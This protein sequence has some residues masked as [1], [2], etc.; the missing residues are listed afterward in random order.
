M[1]QRLDAVVVGAG[2]GGLAAAR[3]LLAAGLRVAVFEAASHPGGT[4]YTFR[5]GGFDFPMG[6]LGFAGP[7]LLDSRLRALGV[8]PP[9][10]HR[11]N[12]YR[13]RAFGLDLPLSLPPAAEA[14]ALAGLF[15]GEAAS[16][17]RFFRTV[18]LADGAGAEEPAA[19]SAD[20]LE[21]LALGEP[22]RRILGSLGTEEPYA[23]L[24]LLA[25][26]WRLMGLEGIWLPEGGPAGVCDRLAASLAMVRGYP[27]APV[28]SGK[29]GTLHLAARVSR[30]LVREGRAAGILLADGQRVEAPTVIANADF[31]TTFLGL[32]GEDDLP[33]SWRRRVEGARL[34]G[35]NLQVSLGVDAARVDLGAFGEAER[36][37]ARRPGGETVRVDWSLPVVRPGDLAGSEMEI[38]LWEG[39]GRSGGGEDR[40]ALVIRVAAD[41]AHFA[42]FRPS[43]G[44]RS[45]EYRPYKTA[46]AEALVSQA[47]G[48]LPGLSRAVRV[49]DVAT[50]LTFQERGGRSAGAVAG[51]SWDHADFHAPA[52]RDLVRTPV[53][54]LYMAGHQAATALMEGGVPTAFRTGILAAECLLGGVPPVPGVSGEE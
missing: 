2:L 34:T 5:R 38:A 20:F 17:R 35:S 6:P 31:K 43:P 7:A 51:W 30:I 46:L 22:L 28:D 11:R 26:M 50:P 48:W 32:L 39:P 9:P 10:A 18:S 3:R 23:S 24:G 54:G 40:A 8:E 52:A 33:R 42:R 47:E 27:G 36:I 44:M 49:M 16:I 41:H 4:A 12:R 25:G 37:I 21:R 1:N 45:G 29:R 14:E 53:R 13:L 19:P 15:P